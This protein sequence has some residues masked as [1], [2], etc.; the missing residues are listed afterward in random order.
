MDDLEGQIYSSKETAA[1]PTLS[2]CVRAYFSKNG[3]VRVIT[4]ASAFTG[5]LLGV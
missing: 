3:G 2:L 5:K 1:L 4:D